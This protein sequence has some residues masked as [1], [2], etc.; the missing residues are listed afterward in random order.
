MIEN[1]TIQKVILIFEQKHSLVNIKNEAYDICLEPLPFN[2]EKDNILLTLRINNS[3]DI[4]Y[5]MHKICEEKY[6]KFQL[7]FYK[8]KLQI[9][10][11]LNSRTLNINQ[12]TD[13]IRLLEQFI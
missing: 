6:A 13:N 4:F 7:S 8:E 10:C 2:N 5:I 12:L 9:S 11:F 3:F 1:Q